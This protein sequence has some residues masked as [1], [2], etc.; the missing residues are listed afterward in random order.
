MLAPPSAPGVARRVPARPPRAAGRRG[1]RHLP[2]GAQTTLA[3]ARGQAMPATSA[4][5]GGT[6]STSVS[7]SPARAATFSPGSTIPT[8]LQGSTAL[9][10]TVSWRLARRRVARSATD[11]LRQRIL[12]THEAGDEPAA[13][14]APPRLHSPQRPE[15]IAPRQGDAL[16]PEQVAEEHAVA[17][18]QHLRRALRQ[19]LRRF[20]IGRA[21]ADHRPPPRRARPHENTAGSVRRAPPPPSGPP[22]TGELT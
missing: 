10:R 2:A 19:L 1:L 13:P 16:S 7:P 11:G 12:L 5:S 20:E 8:R 18:Q 17:R 21:G 4:S 3:S 14:H 22:A 6:P 15:K 9:T